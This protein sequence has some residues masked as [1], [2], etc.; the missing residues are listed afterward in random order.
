MADPEVPAS[1]IDLA[2]AEEETRNVCVCFGGDGCQVP[3]QVCPAAH[4]GCGTTLEWQG[5]QWPAE[6]CPRF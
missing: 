5:G 6:R 1:R 2:R 4:C 3:G